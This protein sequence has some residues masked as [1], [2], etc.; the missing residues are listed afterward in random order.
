MCFMKRKLEAKIFGYSNGY[1][2]SSYFYT[3]LKHLK[4]SFLKI[5][6]YFRILYVISF[7]LS[8]I[9]VSFELMQY[10]VSLSSNSSDKFLDVLGMMPCT[11]V[12]LA[13][14]VK[15]AIVAAY[16]KKISKILDNLKEM[17]PDMENLD[18]KKIVVDNMLTT[19]KFVVFYVNQIT[20][21]ATVWSVIPASIIT[22]NLLMKLIYKSPRSWNENVD[23]PYVIWYP[24]DTHANVFNYFIT[25][26][27]Q[28][29]TGMIF[30]FILFIHLLKHL[31][32]DLIFVTQQEFSCAL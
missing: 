8:I 9:L 2:D 17:W 28:T 16:G 1:S 26:T 14:P 20:I 21:L 6:R 29:Y 15:S 11:L 5:F 31:D 30:L 32:I 4:Q 13:G 27:S 19:K 23:L 7:I 10:Y 3:V 18:V 24:Y 12:T 22:Y 25:F